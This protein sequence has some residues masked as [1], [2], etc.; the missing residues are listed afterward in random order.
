M[1]LSEGDSKYSDQSAQRETRGK[2]EIIDRLLAS[3]QERKVLLQ[4]IG[5]NR[6]K[7]RWS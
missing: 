1:T 2:Y 6:P 3:A 7:N 4:G 5:Y